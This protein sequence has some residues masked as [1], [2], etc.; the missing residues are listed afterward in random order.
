MTTL[1]NNT[2]STK[3]VSLRLPLD[4]YEKYVLEASDFESDLSPYLIEK[5]KWYEDLL[6]E[7]DILENK[8]FDLRQERNKLNEELEKSKVEIQSLRQSVATMRNM[9]ENNKIT[10]D[11]QLQLEREKSAKSQKEYSKSLAEKEEILMAKDKE[12]EELKQEQ[13]STR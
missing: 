12:I 3:V 7:R 2:S 10:A 1:K 11:K 5:L 6:T 13:I 8:F 9:N 4:R